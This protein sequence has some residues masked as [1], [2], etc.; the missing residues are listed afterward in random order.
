MRLGSWGIYSCTNRDKDR[1]IASG[2]E[3]AEFDI[4]KG[5]TA[6]LRV[7]RW[8]DAKRCCGACPCLSSVI[9][10]VIFNDSNDKLF[11]YKESDADDKI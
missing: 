8:E 4:C 7:W 11:Q 10:S 6:L 5:M 1:R 9:E 2:Y 3:L